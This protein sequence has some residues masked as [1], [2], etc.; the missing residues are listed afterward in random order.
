VQLERTVL[1]FE[2]MGFKLTAQQIVR[3]HK[4]GQLDADGIKAFAKSFKRDLRKH[5]PEQ[6]LDRTQ[7]PALSFSATEAGN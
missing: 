3:L 5:P 7:A 1:F 2:V 6:A 4:R